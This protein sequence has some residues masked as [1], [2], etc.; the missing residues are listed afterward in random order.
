MDRPM[1]G[2]RFNEDDILRLIRASE[3]YKESTGSEYMWEI[4]DN[5]TKKLKVYLDQYSES[6]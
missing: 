5:L 3:Y 1:M 4:Y 6:L 2:M